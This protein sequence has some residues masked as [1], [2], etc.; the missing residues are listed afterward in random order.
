MKMR[1][2]FMIT[3]IIVAIGCVEKKTFEDQVKEDLMK[4]VKAKKCELISESAVLS[5]IVVGAVTPIGDTGLIDVE[6]S[7]DY[8]DG[9]ASGHLNWA[10][11]YVAANGGDKVLREVGS[12][13]VE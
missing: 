6:T 10:L 13:K 7:F 8:K 11:L 2:M 4:S 5:N 12:C 1:E 3:F 9:N